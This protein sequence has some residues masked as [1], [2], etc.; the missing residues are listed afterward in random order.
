LLLDGGAVFQQ[1]GIDALPTT[2]VIDRDRK[3]AGRHVGFGPG[4]ETQFEEE[5][6]KLLAPRATSRQ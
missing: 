5:V 2:F 3:I 1:Y 6:Q 4:G